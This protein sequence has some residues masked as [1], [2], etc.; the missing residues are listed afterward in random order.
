MPSIRSVLI[1]CPASL[2]LNWRREAKR[3]LVRPLS[4][5]IAVDTFPA[6]DV[7]VVNYDRLGRHRAALRSREW[8]LLVIDEAHYLKNPKAQ[9]TQEVLGRPK[10][11]AKESIRPIL[12]SRRMFLSGTP[13]LNRPVELWPILRACGWTDWLA[14]VKRYCG[15]YRN[16]FGWDVSGATNL[17]ELQQRLRSELMVRRLKADVLTELPPKVRQVIEVSANGAGH[18][19]QAELELLRRLSPTAADDDFLEAVSRLQQR[20]FGAF[21]ELSRLR[22]ET[23]LAKVQ[24]V[25]EHVIDCVESSPKIIVFGHHKDALGKVRSGLAK[26]S[27]KS[28]VLTGD[29]G[30]DDRQRSVDRF[31]HDPEVQV[32]LGTI[33]AAGVGLT[34]TAANH[35]M[36]AELDWVPGNMSQAEDRAHRIGQRDSVLVQHIVFEGSLDAMIAQTLIRKQQ[37]IEQALDAK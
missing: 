6:T 3:W 20:D 4:V 14:F 18:Q 23:A 30:P 22:H 16:R 25:V 32:F 26:A 2:R 12:A 11:G 7:V 24:A 5:G 9:R 31:Q 21:G 13:I 36:F 8:D 33:G 15:A 35:V 17:D 29:M 10:R 1:I 19:V 34:L 37:V 27:I 28:V